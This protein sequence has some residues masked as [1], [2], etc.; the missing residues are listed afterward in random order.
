M[1]QYGTDQLERINYSSKEWLKV[2]ANITTLVNNFARRSDLVASLS[3][4]PG[5]SNQIA[6]FIPVLAKIELNAG[7][8]FGPTVMPEQIKDLTQR[9]NQFEFPR[10]VGAILHEALHARFSRWS[11]EKAIAGLKD[12]T[13]FDALM[14]LEESRIES[15]GLSTDLTFLPFLRSCAKKFVLNQAEENFHKSPS[16]SSAAILVGLILARVEVGVLRKE[17]VESL[18]KLLNDCLGAE[19]VSKLLELAREFHAHNIDT[20]M[21]LAYPIVKEW[22]KL[23]REKQAEKGEN[24]EVKKQS[25]SSTKSASISPV[26][27]VARSTQ[28]LVNKYSSFPHHSIEELK[29][30][31]RRTA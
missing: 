25:I 15:R 22:V 20:N 17:D 12:K 31:M 2:G 16:S 5:G 19:L 6:S 26:V 23:I 18:S 7:I 8:V 9:K 11:V 29:K 27:A 14:M 3:P 1:K 24:K 10:A 30:P 21:E 13:E 28:S 4:T